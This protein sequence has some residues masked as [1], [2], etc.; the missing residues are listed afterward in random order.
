MVDGTP[1]TI[2]RQHMRPYPSSSVA[3][4]RLGAVGE[5]CKLHSSCTEYS[6]PA[7]HCVSASREP[8]GIM[9]ITCEC[10]SLA[11]ESSDLKTGSPSRGS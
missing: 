2:G 7:K 10:V 4:D 6:N 1:G 3:S 11:C 5:G 9:A 8:S